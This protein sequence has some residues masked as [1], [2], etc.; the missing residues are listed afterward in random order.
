MHFER[1][2]KG[3]EGGKFIVYTRSFKNDVRSY[4]EKSQIWK[5][6]ICIICRSR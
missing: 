5:M 2:V 1:G 4:Q 3:H 6:Y